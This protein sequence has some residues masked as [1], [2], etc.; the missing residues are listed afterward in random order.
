MLVERLYCLEMHVERIYCSERSS[1]ELVL[2]VYLFKNTLRVCKIHWRIH[3]V[4]LRWYSALR[5]ITH[6]MEQKA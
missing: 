2:H 6:V 4:R 1:R 5:I 3:I